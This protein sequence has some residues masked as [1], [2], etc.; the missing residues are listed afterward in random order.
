MQIKLLLSLCLSVCTITTTGQAQEVILGIPTDSATVHT[1]HPTAPPRSGAATSPLIVVSSTPPELFEIGQ[2]LTTDMQALRLVNG[3]SVKLITSEGN[4]LTLVGTAAGVPTRQLDISETH[5][6][7]LEKA[8]AELSEEPY[9][10]VRSGRKPPVSGVVNIAR[11][12]KYCT[13]SSTVKLWRANAK[14]RDT[15]L[16]VPHKPPGKQTKVTFMPQQSTH[17]F[18]FRSGTTYKVQLASGAPSRMTFHKIPT[19]LEFVP[20]RVVWMAKRGCIEQ[21]KQLFPFGE[22]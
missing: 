19:N 1:P 5:E 12:G 15:L 9:V 7:V 3:Q 21:A 22:S 14:N 17:T 20:Y 6:F 10:I 2:I 18:G 16:I 11:S 8:L 4:V 13:R